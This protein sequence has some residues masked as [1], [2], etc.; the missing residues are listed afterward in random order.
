[1]KQKGNKNSRLGSCIIY[2]LK[3]SIERGDREWKITFIR[4]EGKNGG[5]SQTEFW[6]QGRRLEPVGQ[7]IG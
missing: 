1:M 6:R 5:S 2:K 7:A 3:D 4:R